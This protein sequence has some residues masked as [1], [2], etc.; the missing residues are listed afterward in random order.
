MKFHLVRK[1]TNI[2]CIYIII[3]TYKNSHLTNIQFVSQS[4]SYIHFLYYECYFIYI[5]IQIEKCIGDDFND[6]THQFCILM[7][8]FVPIRSTQK[9][10]N[11]WNSTVYKTSVLN[12]LKIS[13]NVAQQFVIKILNHW[14]WSWVLFP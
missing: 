12:E 11:N 5:L 2:P 7:S 10:L 14:N 4:E 1:T 6:I 3:E 13:V 8:L 9:H